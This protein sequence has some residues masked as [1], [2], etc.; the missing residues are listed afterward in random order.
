MDLISWSAAAIRALNEGVTYTEITNNGC[1]VG[2]S[3]GGK[4]VYADG[5]GWYDGTKVAEAIA[6]AR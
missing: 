2:L 4:A 6:A 3:I 1:L 5:N